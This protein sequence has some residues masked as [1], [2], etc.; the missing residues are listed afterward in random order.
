MSSAAEICLDGDPREIV[1]SSFGPDGLISH[2]VPGFEERPEQVKMASSV[3][4]VLEEGGLLLAEAGTGVGKSL[5]YL[6]PA[7]LWAIKTTKRVIISTHT[8]NLQSQLVT[9]DI[10]LLAKAFSAT[11]RDFQ[12]SL[13]KG[14]SHYLCMR[15]WRQA[16]GNVA[17]RTA[18]VVANEEERAVEALFDLTVDGSWDGDRDTLPRPIP[19]R[20]WSEVCS[21]SD[22]CMAAKCVARNECFYQKHRKQL[23]KCHLIVVNHAL[24]S[25]HLAIKGTSQGQG[26]LPNFEALIL[27]EAHHLEDVTRDSLGTEISPSRIRRLADDTIRLSSSG[28]FQKAVTKEGSRQVR[29]TLDDFAA[30]LSSLLEKAGGRRSG[31]FSPK[32]KSRLRDPD[33]IGEDAPKWLRDFSREIATWE[34]FDLSDEERFEVQVL[35]RRYAELADDLDS[36]NHLEGDGDSYVYW[37]EKEEG[38]RR[39]QVV[40]KK[41]PLEVGPHLQEILWSTVPSTVLTSATLATGGNFDYLRRMLGIEQAEELIL[42]SPFNYRQ[43]AVLCVP[44]DSRSQEV[45]SAP[46]NDYVAEKVLQIVDLTLGRA[47]I[48]F[49]N[50]KSMQRVSELARDGIEERGYPFLMQGEAPRNTLLKEFREL[51]NAVLFGLDSFWEGV[52]VPG[53]ALSCVVLAK[54]PFPVPDDPV[55]EAREQLWKAQGL[56]P[57]THYS[58]PLATLKLKQGFGRLIRSKTDRGAVVLLDP[59][60]ATKSYGRI[61]LKSLPP[62]RLTWDLDD[63]AEAVAPVNPEGRIS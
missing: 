7:V 14:R 8:V 31:A 45:N 36:I 33:L 35:R 13:F 28:S 44:R 22:R 29:S 6:M 1:K 39:S 56:V 32:D 37:A 42:G 10:P 12:Y 2:F 9:K 3:W 11:G 55:M 21:E 61:I 49:T 18:M 5:A 40:L 48:L 54:L 25:A 26:L 27:D 58:L 16:Y 62:A 59:R 51:G 41:F 46:F 52:D 19:D 47:F 34:D 20:V 17:Q 23:E 53:D 4:D 38:G 30:V 63:I 15:R 57:F 60:I 50:R 24:L 43:Q